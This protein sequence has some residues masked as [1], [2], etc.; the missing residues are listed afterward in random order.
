MS[1]AEERL[2]AVHRWAV[3][4][5]FVHGWPNFEEAN[6]RDGRGIVY[7]VH[8]LRRDEQVDFRDVL[9]TELAAPDLS[10]VEGCWR[11]V[12]RWAINHGYATG[13]PTFE[14]GDDGRGPVYGTVLLKQGPHIQ[15]QDLVLNELEGR[16]SFAD[17]APSSGR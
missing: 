2:R 12:H 3:V 5:G 6:Y 14:Q 13:I 7:G 16:P 8:L 9:K 4:H 15:W 10:N 1:S 17:R 11:A